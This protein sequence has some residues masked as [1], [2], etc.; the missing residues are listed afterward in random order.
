MFQF[1]A[2]QRQIKKAVVDFVRG[3][4][5][6]ENIDDLIRENRYPESIWKKS[7]DLGFPGIAFPEKY[8]GE[9]LGTIEKTIIAEELCKGDASIGAC[10][11]QA[12][13]GADILLQYGSQKQKETWLP[14]IANART[15]SSVAAAEAGGTGPSAIETRAVKDGDQWAIDG[16][17]T[18]VRNA[19]PLA[20]I[21]IVLCRTDADAD[22]PEKGLSMIL[23][24]A[25]RSGVQL[26]DSGAR[27]G[28]RQVPVG[29]VRFE[30]VRVPLANL[31]GKENR[32]LRQFNAFM[33][34]ARLMSAAQSLGMAR[35]AFERAFAYVRER[36]Q[37]KRKIVDF[38]VTRHK[39]ADM[40]TE[41]EAARLLTYQAAW[42]IDNGSADARMCAMAKLHAART[43]VAVSDE[44]IQLL[45][46]YGYMQEYDVERFF[47]DSKTADILDGNRHTQKDL[48]FQALIG[49]K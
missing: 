33:D 31:I 40:A 21:Y 4:L 27:L 6:K 7:S 38:Q 11:T 14:K 45:G 17:K 41:I 43:A 44:A 2:M 5:K 18:Y 30:S 46:G 22:A 24:E 49:K 15:L 48:I 35:G 42:A 19:G 47:R 10:L 20:G 39:L 3:E 8:E 13:Y 9:G 25:E 37:F 16:H 1:N 23:V 26:S 28:Q 32:G 29:E 34:H 12:G 36:E